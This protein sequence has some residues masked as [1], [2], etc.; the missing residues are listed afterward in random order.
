MLINNHRF[1]KSKSD[2]HGNGIFTN[3]PIVKGEILWAFM[4]PDF[5]KDP[6]MAS[7]EDLH[8]GSISRI[9]GKLIVCMDNARWWNFGFPHNCDEIDGVFSNGERVVVALRDI[10]AGEELLIGPLSDSD[11]NRK[12]GITC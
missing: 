5:Y 8:F 4:E 12:L 3:S 11:I 10:S 7:L 6:S 2:I 9:T 1:Y